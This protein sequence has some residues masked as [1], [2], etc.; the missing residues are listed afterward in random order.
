MLDLLSQMTGGS[1]T[2][3]EIKAR[4]DGGHGLQSQSGRTECWLDGWI[5]VPPEMVPGIN[6]TLGYCDLQIEDGVLVGFT[7]RE[8]PVPPD[9]RTPAEKRED[10]YNTMEII[11]Y[12]D[13]KIT[14]TAAATLWEYY[15]A[16]GATEEAGELTEL[17]AAAKAKIREM[18]PD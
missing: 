9:T 6:K 11:E 18:Y 2:I 7:P 16:E 10:A 17:I 12:R 1:L 15:S 5:A 3:I 8:I 13:K 14:V 4:E